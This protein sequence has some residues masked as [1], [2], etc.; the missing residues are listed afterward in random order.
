MAHYIYSFTSADFVASLKKFVQEHLSD[1][2]RDAY[3]VLLSGS[4]SLGFIE[5]PRDVDLSIILDPA[6]PGVGPFGA[7]YINKTNRRFCRFDGYAVTLDFHYRRLTLDDYNCYTN[8]WM[9]RFNQLLWAREDAD[10]DLLRRQGYVDLDFL[11]RNLPT[12]APACL[13]FLAAEK[14]KRAPRKQLYY[15]YGMTCILTHQTFDFTDEEKKTLNL[16][17]DGSGDDRA[18]I[19]D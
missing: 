12:L 7:G 3:A 1:I 9:F 14:E 8:V 6:L 11:Q 18:A 4:V 13:R 5:N 16:L 15:I 2:F 10:F 17:H 19:V